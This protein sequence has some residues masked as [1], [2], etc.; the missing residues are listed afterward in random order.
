MPVF[1]AEMTR[2]REAAIAAEAACIMVVLSTKTSAQEATIAG[3]RATLHVKATED[4][5]AMAKRKARER[6]SRVEAE[7]NVVLASAHDDAEDLVW[8][9]SLLEGELREEHRAW[10][11]A[12]ENSHGL[13]DAASN[14]EHRW[15]VSEREW[16][17]QF[18]ELT[19]L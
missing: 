12:E 10:K 8:K 7:N 11:L 4:R 9:I 18:D 15:E 17:E 1:L 16:R 3:D 2:V 14:A 19:L 5:V 13:S 6:I